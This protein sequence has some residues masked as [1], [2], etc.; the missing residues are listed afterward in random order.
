M[1]AEM[2]RAD[3]LTVGRSDR[4]D[5]RNSRYSQFCEHSSQAYPWRWQHLRIV[6]F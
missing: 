3:R 2:F 1:G 5:E 4:L 6:E